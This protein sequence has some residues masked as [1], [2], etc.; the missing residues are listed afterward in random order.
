MQLDKRLQFQIYKM[1]P[2]PPSFSV[3]PVWNYF[4]SYPTAELAK[5]SMETLKMFSNAGTQFKI[6]EA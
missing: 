2:V 1:D 5:K 6:I 4:C 3:E